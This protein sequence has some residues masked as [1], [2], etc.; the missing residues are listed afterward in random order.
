MGAALSGRGASDLVGALSY[1]L[2][3]AFGL[4]GAPPSWVWCVWP[5]R[6]GCGLG[7][8]PLALCGASGV[9]GASEMVEAPMTW[10]APLTGWAPV[11][12]WAPLTGWAPHA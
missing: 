9:E 3:E 4:L 8:A 7:W 1:D 2:V 5:S 11:T 6:G 10:W 12:G